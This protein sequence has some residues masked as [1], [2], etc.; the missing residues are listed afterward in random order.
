MSTFIQRYNIVNYKKIDSY[1]Y[2]LSSFRPLSVQNS[3][4]ITQTKIE[5]NVIHNVL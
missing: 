2:C 3:F 1:K 4:Y 5:P